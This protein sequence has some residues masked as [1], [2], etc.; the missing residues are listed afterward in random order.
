MPRFLIERDW[1]NAGLLSP[2]ELKDMAQ[3]SCEVLGNMPAVVHWVHSYV[4]DNQ[5]FCVYIAPDMEALLEHASYGGFS[6]KK[7]SRIKQIIDPV[8]AEE[9][10]G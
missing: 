1:P 7:I 2:N 6:A 10:T 5:L 9:T 8:T 4:T 3:L